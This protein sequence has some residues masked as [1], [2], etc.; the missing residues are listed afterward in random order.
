[1]PVVRRLLSRP[2]IKRAHHGCLAGQ[3]S[4]VELIVPMS[5]ISLSVPQNTLT[6]RA[7]G[8]YLGRTISREVQVHERTRLLGGAY[9][10]RNGSM[11]RGSPRFAGRDGDGR[12]ARGPAIIRICCRLDGPPPPL[13]PPRQRPPAYHC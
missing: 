10:V 13:S 7:A 8:L 5:R 3:K 6:A 12:V 1:M 4:V 2:Q 9:V 11:V